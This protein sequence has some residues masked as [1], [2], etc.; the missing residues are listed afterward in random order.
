MVC[1]ANRLTAGAR[2]IILDHDISDEELRARLFA[3]V[4]RNLLLENLAGMLSVPPELRNSPSRDPL[5]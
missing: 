1:P 3:V 4:S 5:D 2:W